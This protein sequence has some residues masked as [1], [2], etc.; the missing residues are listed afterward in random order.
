MASWK[1]G[2]SW[3]KGPKSS[4]PQQGQSDHPDLL[5]KAKEAS[6]EEPG[7]KR[8]WRRIPAGKVGRAMGALQLTL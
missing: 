6:A 7:Y 5:P 8:F 3:D 2:P 4:Q 1:N